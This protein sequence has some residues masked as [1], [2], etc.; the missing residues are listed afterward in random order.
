MFLLCL[1]NFSFG[2]IDAQ[3]NKEAP[4]PTIYNLKK[5]KSQDPSSE[6]SEQN[7]AQEYNS[8]PNRSGYSGAA[9]FKTI[10][11]P[12][13]GQASEGHNWKG[14]AFPL[15]TLGVLANVGVKYS[16]FKKADSEYK[17][18]FGGDGTLFLLLN[19]EPLNTLNLIQT[20]QRG[21][22]LERSAENLAQASQIYG[23]WMAICLLDMMI[24]KPTAVAS[25]NYERPGIALGR[26]EKGNIQLDMEPKRVQ[27]ALGNQ[28]WE[29]SGKIFWQ[30][31]F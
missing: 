6:N 7:L 18:L 10:L 19:L 20:T 1:I 17:D 23:A 16:D 8:A 15:I 4:F 21:E 25:L 12:G 9:Y 22:A 30:N 14:Y 27:T 24:F 5:K 31:S 11:F 28:E 2:E 3:E 29:N 26:T 13:W